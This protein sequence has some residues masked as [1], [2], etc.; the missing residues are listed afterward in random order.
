MKMKKNPSVDKKKGSRNSR[1]KSLRRRRMTTPTA[2]VPIFNTKDFESNDG[3]LTTVWGPPMWHYLHTMSF[4]YPVKPTAEDKK[5]YRQFIDTL[6]Y[7]LP[8]GKCRE[9]LKKNFKKLPLTTE[10]MASRHTFSRY[11][12]DLHEL[13]NTMLKKKSNLTYDQVRERYEHFRSR[14]GKSPSLQKTRRKSKSKTPK[15]EKGCT[16]PLTGEKSKCVLQIIPRSDPTESLTVDK[17]CEKVRIFN[18]EV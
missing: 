1:R 14:C 2:S 3:M 17:K 6:Q 9:N 5:H 10:V 18:D 11:I 8:C 4:N 15:K 13:I 16:D 12:Y 7:V